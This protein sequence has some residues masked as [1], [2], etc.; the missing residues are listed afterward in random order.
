MRDGKSPGEKS[1][2]EESPGEGSPDEESPGEKSP[3][4]KSPSEEPPDEEVLELDGEA[5]GGQLLR[6]ALALS[7][8]SQTPFRMENIRGNRPTPGLKSQH[9]TGVHAAAEVCDA[10]VEGAE[11]ESE[12]LT[13]RPGAPT[14]GRV[15][16]EIGTAGSLLL[17]FDALVPIATR[18]DRPLAVTATGG[19]DVKW[20]PTMAH[21]RRVKLPLVRNAGLFGTV[22]S[23]RS[24]GTGFYPAGGGEATLLLAPSEMDPI[25]ATDRGSLEGVRIYSKSSADLAE[26]DVAE[27]QAAGAVEEFL[28]GLDEE[29]PVT[30]R[31]VS[32]VETLSTGSAIA[33]ALDYEETTA[34][35]DALGEKGKPAEEVGAEVAEKALGFHEGVGAVDAHTAD[36]L[37]VLLALAG[38]QVAIPEVT[39]HVRTGVD[40][41]NEFGF[42]VEIEE[43]ESGEPAILTAPRSE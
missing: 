21:Y 24:G 15:E 40:L 36:Q 16:V 31:T 28:A 18:L 29:I 34:G 3:D 1:P 6:T 38:G 30:E 43:G 17:L 27:R 7:M 10:A 19:T 12:E 32:A 35:F 22:E 8:V 11:P 37:V 23:A 5:G 41:V 2:D 9:L 33:V 39:A 13:F 25:E 14:G 4:E 20:S 26:A 42:P